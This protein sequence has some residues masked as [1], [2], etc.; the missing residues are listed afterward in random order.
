MTTF[1][2][3]H[4]LASYGPY[5]PNRDDQGRPKQA[6]VGGAQRSRLLRTAVRKSATVSMR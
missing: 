6:M 1:L 5:N 2:R 3:F 4:L